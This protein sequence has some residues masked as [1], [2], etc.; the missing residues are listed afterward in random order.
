MAFVRTGSEETAARAAEALLRGELAVFPTETYYALGA[1][2]TRPEGLRRLLEAKGGRDGA[3]VSVL[4]SGPAMA[5]AWARD[6]PPEAEAL[7]ERWWPGPL[8]LVLDAAPRTPEIVTAGTGTIGMRASPDPFCRSLLSR[9]DA[10]VTATSANPSGLPPP[11]DAETARGYFGD[12]VALYADGGRT[13]GGAASTVARVRAGRVEVLRP[14]PI[15]PGAAP[16]G[17]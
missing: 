9:L 8:T 14:G 11:R 1:L 6:V 13:P 5:R 10:P 2:I 4:V 16:R 7:M 3:P 12:R 17:A 15:D